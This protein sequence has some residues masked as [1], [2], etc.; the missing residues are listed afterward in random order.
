MVFSTPCW[1]SVAKPARTRPGRR[2]FWL[3]LLGLLI[4]PGSG[5]ADEFRIVNASTRQEQGVYLLSADIRYQLS[6]AA[7][8]A[9]ANSVPLTF[10]LRMQVRRQRAWLWDV[11]VASLEQRFRLNYH[12]LAQQY[13]VT[14]VNSDALDSFPTLEAAV[15]FMGKIRDFPLLDRSLL[16]PGQ[17]YQVWLRAELDIESLPAPLRPLAYL[18]SAWR[19]NSNWVSWPL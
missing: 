4:L 15:E 14:N 18:S 10:A 5:G 19:L 8:D 2:G 12:A 16:E 6:P 13:V 11:T 9:L 3:L 1:A 17:P 7:R